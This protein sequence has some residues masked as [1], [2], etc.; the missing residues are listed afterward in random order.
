MTGSP[1]IISSKWVYRTKIDA[2]GKKRYKATLVIK[3]YKHV[4][5]IDYEETFAPVARLSTLRMLLALAVSRHWHVHQMDVVTAFLYPKIDGVVV[6]EPLPEIEWLHSCFGNRICLLQK[7][8]Y[9]L[10]QAR[11]FW[12][13]EIDRTLKQ[14]GFIQSLADSN[15]YTSDKVILILYVDNILIASPDIGLVESTKK[16]L[17]NYYQMKD[18]GPIR[19]FLGLEIHQEK[20]KITVR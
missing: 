20:D 16:Q 13:Q 14:M 18:L 2:D 19:Q 3:G 7:A 17:Y 5:G 9:G 12:F 15:L 4:N 6:M 10:K 11:G 8:L 1:K